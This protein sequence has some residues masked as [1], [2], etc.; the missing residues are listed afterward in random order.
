MTK[1]K[2]DSTEDSGDPT[3]RI[4]V[5]AEATPVQQAYW[6]PARVVQFIMGQI[7]LGELQQIGK[8]E[9]Y[10]I[11]EVGYRF[12]TEGKLDNAKKIYEGLLAL[13]PRD[14]YF[15]TVL[16][17]IAQQR[18]ELEQADKLYTRALELNPFSATASANRGEVRFL[19]GDLSAAAVDLRRALELDVETRERSTQRAKVT[20]RTVEAKLAPSDEDPT[21]TKAAVA[22]PTK[23]PVAPPAKA[24]V[25]PPAKAA[26]APPA[27]PPAKSEAKAKPAAAKASSTKSALKRS[28]SK[29]GT[30]TKRR[31]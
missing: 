21:D 28:T 17:S 22:P 4:N 6:H 14:A 27:K 16:G 20:L 3:E 5:G 23:A 13:D 19:R 18:G 7:T 9:Q 25:A 31:S 10:K 1:S 30:S 11:A 29:A 26:V 8:E 2:A 12:L 15:N 24:P